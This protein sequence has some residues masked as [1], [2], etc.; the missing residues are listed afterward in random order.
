MEEEDRILVTFV[1]D[2][3]NEF[4]LEE[5]DYFEYEGK[6]YGVLIDPELPDDAEYFE[7]CIMEI[8]VNEE[9]DIEEYIPVEDEVLMDKLFEL[10]KERMESWDEEEEE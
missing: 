2:D 3:G 8:T 7:I 10:A 9:E 6:Q 4:I 1:D 5:I